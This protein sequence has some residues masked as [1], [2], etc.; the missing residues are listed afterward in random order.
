[1]V[2]TL[3]LEKLRTQL[4]SLEASLR[5]KAQKMPRECRSSGLQPTLE[6]VGFCCQE[7]TQVNLPVRVE[8]DLIRAKLGA[9]YEP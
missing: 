7:G 8:G 3:M 6:E 4:F 5:L 9:Q 2:Q 1:M